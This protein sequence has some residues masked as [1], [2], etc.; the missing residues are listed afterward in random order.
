M[1][2]AGRGVRDEGHLVKWITLPALRILPIQSIALTAG[3]G[4]ICGTTCG[5]CAPKT[6]ADIVDDVFKIK[7][8]VY[9]VMQVQDVVTRIGLGY[10]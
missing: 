6:A 8:A 2:L 3:R 4:R 7:V 5:K 9:M 10:M 1:L